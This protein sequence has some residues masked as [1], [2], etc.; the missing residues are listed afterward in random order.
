MYEQV[1][2][3]Y[4]TCYSESW[5]QGCRCFEQ[6][7]IMDDMNDLGS[8][9]LRPSSSGLYMIWMIQHHDLRVVD[10]MNDFGSWAHGSRYYVQIK[11]V[12]DMNNLGLWVQGSGCY[13]QLK[14]MD[15]MNNSGC[16]EFKP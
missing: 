4:D 3:L 9:E 16:C 8:R 2:A 12:V 14:A 1:K 10:D 11:V 13:E 15:D 5:A 7:N 6:L